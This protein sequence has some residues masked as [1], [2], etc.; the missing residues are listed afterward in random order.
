MFS[1]AIKGLVSPVATVAQLTKDDVAL[2]WL[3]HQDQT[4]AATIAL[5]A[6]QGSA[7]IQ[8]IYS[9]AGLKLGFPDPA[10]DSRVPDI[11]VQPEVGVIYTNSTAKDAE[12]GGFTLDDVN[13]ALLVAAPQL[14]P[15][16]LQLPVETT[17][18]APSILQALS[19]DPNALQAVEVQ[20]T[21]VLP[22]LF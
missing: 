16:T 19:L 2:I 15:L 1:N 14:A 7:F 4:N 17:Q 13:V 20:R 5:Q 6:G 11:I 3:A 9:G 18:I 22:R 8:T 10:T 12:H 21:Q